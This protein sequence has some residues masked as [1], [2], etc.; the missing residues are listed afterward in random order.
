MNNPNQKYFTSVDAQSDISAD[1]KDAHFPHITKIASSGEYVYNK[2]IDSYVTS[3]Y[4]QL[5]YANMGDVVYCDSSN[6]LYRCDPLNRELFETSGEFT[7]IGVVIANNDSLKPGKVVIMSTSMGVGMPAYNDTLLNSIK[8]SEL[9][10]PASQITLTGQEATAI[11]KQKWID[12]GSPKKQYSNNIDLVTNYA[13]G[14]FTAGSWYLPTQKELKIIENI[15]DP[16]FFIKVGMNEGAAYLW[17]STYEFGI[18][19]NEEG[20]SPQW[21]NVLFS[22]CNCFTRGVNGTD[23]VISNGNWIISQHKYKALSGYTFVGQA[24]QTEW[25]YGK[26]FGLTDYTIPS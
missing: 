19:D 25:T 2:N 23:M 9:D 16:E 10:K 24:P 13:I 21:K 18:F 7:K 20:F 17:S 12:A 22:F 14:P 3:E 26:I 8:D 15:T 11:L 1:I 6:N 4:S 5:K